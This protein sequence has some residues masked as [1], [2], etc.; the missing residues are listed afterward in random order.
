MQLRSLQQTNRTLN[1]AALLCKYKSG[2]TDCPGTASAQA[3][4]GSACQG[5]PNQ[6]ACSSG[7]PRAPDP[8]YLLSLLFI[9]AVEEIKQKHK[10]LVLSGKGGVGKSTFGAHLAHGLAGDDSKEVHHSGSGWSP[11]GVSLQDVRKEIAFCR[12]VNLP[13]IGVVENMS[14]FVCPKCKVRQISLVGSFTFCNEGKSFLSGVP[15]AAATA[16][17]RSIIHR[18]RSAGMKQESQA[19]WKYVCLREL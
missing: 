4:K 6:A 19:T 13:I 11:V 1:K 10:V 5:C 16:A 12:K 14:G 7:R 2:P 3:G 15:E 17:Y 18:R 8:G 9:A